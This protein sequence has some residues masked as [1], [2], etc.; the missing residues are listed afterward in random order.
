MWRPPHYAGILVVTRPSCRETA[1][2][3][4]SPEKMF[5]SN[6]GTRIEFSRGEVPLLVV[7]AFRRRLL[8][9]SA[10]PFETHHDERVDGNGAAPP[11]PATQPAPAALPGRPTRRR[12]V[13]R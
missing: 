4:G 6:R 9:L 1:S 7:F 2:R 5:C 12:P 11:G 13:F 10:N 3:R 8:L